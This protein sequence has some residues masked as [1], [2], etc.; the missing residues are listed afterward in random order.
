MSAAGRFAISFGGPLLLL[1]AAAVTAW[2]ALGDAQTSFG[3]MRLTPLPARRDPTPLATP[4]D[5]PP[6]TLE[7]ISSAQAELRNALLPYSSAPLLAG[8]GFAARRDDANAASQCMT[9]A[10]YYEAGNEPDAGKR[11]VAQ[12]ILNR[13]ASPA[14]PKTVCAVVQQGAN[15]PGCQFTFMCD[16]SLSRAPNPIGWT[17]AHQIADDALQGYVDAT[18]GGATHYHADYVFP[19]WAPT[20]IKLAKIGRHIFYRWP[21]AQI[22]PSTLVASPS[23]TDAP[24]AQSPAEAT[25]PPA[26][27]LDTAASAPSLATSPA[28]EAPKAQ[29]QPAPAIAPV[30]GSSP[31]PA[32]ASAPSSFAVQPAPHRAVPETKMR[33]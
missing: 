26:L 30:A 10:I 18:V 23:P 12:V 5:P 16:G 21:G 13:V 14:F 11:A 6:T 8:A 28:F 29:P 25:L 1:G 33:E 20:M 4:S 32:R 2:L 3:P 31:P 15:R 22:A 19:T 24:A 17:R 27:P 7:P 9:Q